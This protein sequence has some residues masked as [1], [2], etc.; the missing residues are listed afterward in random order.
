MQQWETE[1]LEVISVVNWLSIL[2]DF[3]C[4]EY[5]NKA[6]IRTEKLRKRTIIC[7]CSVKASESLYENSIY[8][9]ILEVY[10]TDI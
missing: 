10:L 1:G 3:Y 2:M 6:F 8:L 5:T 4:Y 9:F 7:L